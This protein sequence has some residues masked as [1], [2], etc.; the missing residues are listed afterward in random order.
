MWLTNAYLRKIEGF[1]AKC[2]R[3]IFFVSLLLP[4]VTLFFWSGSTLP[5]AACH[6]RRRE[7]VPEEFLVELLR[8]F[9]GILQHGNAPIKFKRTLFTMLP[10]NTRAKLVTDFRPIT[11][12]WLFYSG[13]AYM[14]LARV[15]QS[16]ESSTRS[17]TRFSPR[18]KNGRTRSDN[19]KKIRIRAEQLDCHCG[20]SVFASIKHFRPQLIW[21]FGCFYHN[22]RGVA[23]YGAG[24]SRKFDMLSGVQRCNKGAC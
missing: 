10:K 15:E 23:R 16:L 13:F 18:P 24:D 7:H 20:S 22:Q 5:L 6:L 8:F 3:S 11:K 12:I 1:Q 14:I 19:Q 17:T 21:N 4:A 9:T 2:L